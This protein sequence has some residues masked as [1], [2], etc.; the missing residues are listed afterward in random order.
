[1]SKMWK[2]LKII[3]LIFVGLLVLALIGG[4]IF[5][6]TF[7][8]KK[9]K[10]QIIEAAQKS[11]GRPVSFDDI[12]L[13]V[14]LQEGIRMNL[15]NFTIA[16]N[17]QFGQDPFLQVSDV[18]V[19]VDILSF[20]NARQ[21]SI[22]NIVVQSPQINVIRNAA[23][24]LNVET[25]GKTPEAAAASSPQ[26]S[27]Q[28]AG[29]PGQSPA[30]SSPT[31]SAASLP[32][33]FIN[34][35]RV[36]NARLNYID[37][38]VT[39]ALEASVSKLDI[40]VDHFS[41]N[42]PFGF[43]VEAAILSQQKNL[44]VDGTAQLNLRSNEVRL[45]NVRVVTD[46]GLLSL[47]EIRRLPMLKGSPIPDVLSG[48][49]TA[50]VRECTASD[51][52]VASL[53][54]DTRLTNGQIT[55]AQV[56][57]E[58]ALDLRSIDL[59]VLDFSLDRPFKLGLQAAYLSEVPNIDFK[60]TV[61]F[62]MKTQGVHVKNAN[63]VT[64][65]GLW[66]LA[67]LKSS[68]APLK[69]V[70]M[71]EKMAGQLQLAL[72]DFTAG[73][74]GLESIAA[75]VLL[76]NGEVL[77]EKAV[78]GVSLQIS[79]MNLALKDVSLDGP[80]QLS[81]QAGLFSD[82]P[83]ISVD[84]V[85]KLNQ[86]T[87]EL[88]LSN[89]K[90]AVDLDALPLAKI[91]TAVAALKDVPMP[92]MLGGKLTALIKDLKAGPKGMGS[93]LADVN[94]ADGRVSMKEAAPGISFDASRIDLSVMNLSLTEPFQ[95]SVKMAYLSE[96]PNI[97]FG[98]QIAYNM[99]TQEARLKDSSLSVD[100]DRLNLEQL[101]ATVAAL[102]DV[103]LPE[104]MAGDLSV[105]IND[106]TTGPKGLGKVL[107]DV[108]WK[109]GAISLKN[110]APGVSVAA[111]KID[112]SVKDASLGDPFSFAL[113]AAY[114]NDEPNIDLGGKVTV[115]QVSQVIRLKD[116]VF[117]TDL[118]AFSMDQLRASV[119]SLKDVPLPQSLKGRF[120]LVITEATAGAQGLMALNTQGTLSDGSIRMK[121]LAVP[122]DAVDL[123]FQADQTKAVIDGLSMKI[124]K[125]TVSAQAT[126]TD[127][128]TKQD[129]NGQLEAK[130]IDLT[131]VV[132]QEKAPVKVAGLLYAN[133][134]A[135]GM[136]SDLNSIVGDGAIEVK[137]GKLKDL[138]VLKLVLD[139]ISVIPNLS[140]K[141][142]ASLPEKY[143]AKL[144]DKDTEI[145]KIAATVAIAGGQINVTPI[146]V[147]ADEFAF[148]G[149]CQADFTQKYS[150]SGAFM[151]P[152]ELAS[153]MIKGAPELQ[154]LL[155]MQG[156]ISFPLK[157]SGKGAG[158]PGFTP[159]VGSLMKNAV[160]NKGK[161]ELGRALRDVLGTPE[162]EAPG[163]GPEE[164]KTSPE[165]EIIDG[166]FGTI[167]K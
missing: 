125:G 54:L 53:A 161:E 31:P 120:N 107:A 119:A 104:S 21:I 159:D 126:V 90:I 25:I 143:I 73:P 109:D 32:A 167:F 118:S 38:S 93:V 43:F 96:M 30:A 62:D 82:I 145:T 80:F 40:G 55:I 113:K 60:G 129:F 26:S 77:M 148:N 131:E 46:L 52:G 28:P 27:A 152:A 15:R 98:G 138:N 123:K 67:K 6:K 59:E 50:T 22:P 114:L 45:S 18:S 63:F 70:P 29:A 14:S 75:D 1:M 3:L 160:I 142:K 87:Q 97:A 149:Q 111:S 83:N 71:P 105:R 17:P 154:Y 157:V 133:I 165:K 85:T 57:P 158:V 127:Y 110:I 137:E 136:G 81:F 115:N 5:L 166:I 48:Q 163:T 108:N 86:K 4:F 58:I 153:A 164:K 76:Q 42:G 19:G 144:E 112:L 39:P 24:K 9:Y 151:I 47:D 64:D 103:P 128:M 69:D 150:L 147:Q 65:L 10:P 68:V 84:G 56:A 101:K 89:F 155:D 72:K 122:I 8:I 139:K 20:I 37:Q 88:D 74:K 156:N 140:E 35:L 146:D 92:Q 94:L 13:K 66:P 61:A 49:F 16:E 134:K 33:I 41:L 106:L 100:L 44:K 117:K 141:V 2:V 102:K 99:Q 132:A 23:G 162:P 11:L 135:Q 12:D 91:K 78:P 7:D 34:S 124:G 36:E 121:E 95:V 116:V 79:K 130:G 51:K